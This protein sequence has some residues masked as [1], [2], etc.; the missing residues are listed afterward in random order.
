MFR[1]NPI[2]FII[3]VLLIYEWG[4]GLVMLFFWWLNTLRT[5]LTITDR[6][7]ILRRGLLKKFTTDVFHEDIRNVQLGQFFFKEFFE[8]AASESQVRDKRMS[9]LTQSAC[10]TQQ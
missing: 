9:R 5:T 6:R 8:S 7:T 4:L 3:C 1:N 2:G 10:L